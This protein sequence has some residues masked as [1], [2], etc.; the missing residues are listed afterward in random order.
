MR[1]QHFRYG[2]EDVVHGAKRVA[3]ERI[4]LV[5]TDRGD[6]N[7]RGVFRP[8]AAEAH[9]FSLKPIHPRHA[10]VE[11]DYCKVLAQKVLS[12][13]IPQELFKKLELAVKY[14]GELKTEEIGDDAARAIVEWLRRGGLNHAWTFGKV[15]CPQ[16]SK[17]SLEF[18]NRDMLVVIC[19]NC[20]GEKAASPTTRGRMPLR[21][22]ARAA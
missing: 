4:R 19:S 12:G 8:F 9:L 21:P 13:E 2:R 20:M 5:L 10:H 6:E 16:C 22:Y 18:Q 1:A 15:P 7:N 3:L 17:E 14:S 11:Q